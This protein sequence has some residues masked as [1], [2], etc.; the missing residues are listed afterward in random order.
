MHASVSAVWYDTSFV[1]KIVL[2]KFS[3]LTVLIFP[4][5]I[6]AEVFVFLCFNSDKIDILC[7]AF[8]S[9][10]NHSKVLWV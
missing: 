7:F 3:W 10:G 9:M 4:W 6:I 8:A 5:N 2:F 1:H